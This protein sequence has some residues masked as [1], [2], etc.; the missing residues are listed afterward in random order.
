MLAGIL[1]THRATNSD[2]V[3]AGSVCLAGTVLLSVLRLIVPYSSTPPAKISEPSSYSKFLTK[4]VEYVRRW[5]LINVIF[6]RMKL[7]LNIMPSKQAVGLLTKAA[8]VRI[9]RNFCCVEARSQSDSVVSAMVRRPMKP[10]Q[11]F[12]QLTSREQLYTEFF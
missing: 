4:I 12:H 7:G 10:F 2:R 8:V 9:H 1:L 6:K 11:W 3:A 5:I